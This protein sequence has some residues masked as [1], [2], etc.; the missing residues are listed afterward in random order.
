MSLD[1]GDAR[2]RKKVSFG[3]TEVTSK[4]DDG[5][6]GRRPMEVDPVQSVKTMTKKKQE[7]MELRRIPFWAECPHCRMTRGTTQH[8][9]TKN[10]KDR[11]VALQADFCFRNLVTGTFAKN[12]PTAPN[13]KVLVMTEMS[14]RMIGCLLVGTNADNTSTWIRHW[15]N[16][17]GL[18]I[19]GSAVLL[20]TGSETAVSA[21]IKRAN[22]EIWVVTQ[23]APPGHE[24]V[25]GVERM[26]TL[27]E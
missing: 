16:A 6:T 25:G 13:M 27:K 1:L 20:R 12:Q 5:Q 8:R 17:F 7:E 23:R 2:K 24:A 4:V 22:P 11:P 9:R 14:T 15:M 18:D 26:R 19:A 21:M 3:G 10:A